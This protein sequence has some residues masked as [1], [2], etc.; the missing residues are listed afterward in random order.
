MASRCWK[1]IGYRLAAIAAGAAV[2]LVLAAVCLFVYVRIQTA[3]HKSLSPGLRRIPFVESVFVD[4]HFL[5]LEKEMQKVRERKR[6]AYMRE[7]KARRGAMDVVSEC[8]ANSPTFESVRCFDEGVTLHTAIFEATEMYGHVRYRFRPMVDVYYLRLWS[9]ICD[10]DAVCPATPEIEESLRNCAVNLKVRFRTD[11][12]GF[13]PTEYPPAPGIP[14]VLFLGDSFTEGLWVAPSDTFANQFGHMMHED[15]I[16]AAS[17]NLGVNGYS[18]MEMCWMLE[19]WSAALRGKVAVFNLFLNDVGNSAKIIFQGLVPE[20]NFRS[21]FRYLDRA[22]DFC[23]RSGICM[24]V[25]VIPDKGQFA[26]KRHVT[27]FQDRVREWTRAHNLPYLD[28]R[29]EFDKE[30]VSGLYIFP[31]DGHFTVKGHRRY[32]RFLY[33]HMKEQLAVLRREA[34]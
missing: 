34:G 15:G 13:R 30:N 10:L 3:R 21:M 2:G 17:V 14:S 22:R 9:G 31:T 20:E 6:Q 24:V 18:A 7:M 32:A 11:R 19:H 29:A 25:A 8:L 5:A 1:A 26:E 4:K 33:D 27:V 28:P 23:E 12:H 16:E